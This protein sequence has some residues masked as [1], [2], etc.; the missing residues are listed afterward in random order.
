MNLYFMR[1]PEKEIDKQYNT[2]N[3]VASHV[4]TV[5]KFIYKYIN[6]HNCFHVAR[7]TVSSYDLRIGFR[8]KIKQRHWQL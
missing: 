8:V 7:K 3:G 4:A 5:I 1:L 6:V 2:E